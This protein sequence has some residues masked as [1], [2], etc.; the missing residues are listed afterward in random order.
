MNSGEWD[1]LDADGRAWLSAALG[2]DTVDVAPAPEANGN[3]NVAVQPPTPAPPTPAPPTPQGAGAAERRA[4]E[5]A[6]S[7]RLMALFDIAAS[8]NASDIHVSV[9]SRPYVRVK[10]EL[11][12]VREFDHLGAEELDAFLMSL[13]SPAQQAILQTSGDLDAALHLVTR[14]GRLR[15]RASVFRQTGTLAAAFR[16]IPSSIPTID[17]LGLPPLVRRFA[18]LDHGLV[19]VTGRTGSGKSTTL[20]A[21]IEAIN[22]SRATHIVTVEDPIE[23]QYEPMQA[24]IQQREVGIDTQSFAVALRHA[25][26]Q[27]P[28]VILLGELRDLETIR[29]ALTA[30]ETGHL[31]L[32]TLHSG[33]AAGAIHR[34]IDVFPADQQSQIR[35]QLAL[36]LQG[37]LSQSLER[38]GDRLVPVTEALVATGAVRNLIRDDK[39]HQLKSV[40]ETGAEDGM[41][42]MEQSR[43]AVSS[44]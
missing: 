11:R 40:I 17:E 6:A 41:H 34:L 10:G 43:A 23:Y 31:V 16:L 14:S 3:G 7:H 32:A 15:I 4:A 27:D 22:R 19:L 25:L 35:S 1:G 5:P 26:R 39:V 33:D 36:S 44:W 24:L 42:T 2:P 37:I 13:V 38:I 9:G 29:T 21:M 30:A 8:L 18:D 28:D 12:P 20:A